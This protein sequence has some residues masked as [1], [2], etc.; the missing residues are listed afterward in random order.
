MQKTQNAGGAP[1]VLSGKQDKPDEVAQRA[2][3]QKSDA[4]KLQELMA[5]LA[6]AKAEADGLRTALAAK[7]T[8]RSAAPK[9][10]WL[11][12]YSELH[13]ISIDENEQ[14]NLLRTLDR[15][16]IYNALTKALRLFK[17]SDMP[18]LLVNVCSEIAVAGADGKKLTAEQLI[19]KTLI[20]GTK[21]SVNI[22]TGKVVDDQTGD[23]AAESVS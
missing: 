17:V 8:T 1:K 15:D 22:A 18:E 23:E 6:A 4:T 13:G 20:K 11:S 7:V 10:A 12:T 16:A 2:A 21:H 9:S 5:E 14:L 3:T 19:T